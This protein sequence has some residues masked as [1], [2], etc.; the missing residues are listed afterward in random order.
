M[1]DNYEIRIEKFQHPD[2]NNCEV[3]VLFINNS[4]DL[5]SFRFLCNEAVQGGRKGQPAAKTSHKGKAYKIAELYEHL[6]NKGLTWQTAEEEDIREI[7]NSMLHW[8]INN[9][10][11]PKD[12][13]MI[14]EFGKKELA[15]EA[16]KNDSMNQKLSLWLK[17]YKYQIKKQQNLKLIPSTKMIEIAIA[18]AKLQ[19]LHGTKIGHNKILIERW[20]LLAPPSPKSL[21]Y[22][23]I[24]E[25]EYE[26][27]K[28]QL[29]RIDPVYAAIADFAVS[30]GL[31]KSAV[32]N[33]VKPSFF[34]SIFRDM[35]QGGKSFYTSFRPMH[36]KNKGGRI[37][38]V[39]VPITVIQEINTIYLTTL[40]EDRKNRY[41]MKCNDDLDYMWFREDGKKIEAHDLDLAFRK[42]S[43]EMNR[44]M[45]INNIKPHTLRHSFATW[46]VIRGAKQLGINLLTLN[47]GEIPNLI[48]WVQLQLAHVSDTTTNIYIVTAILLLTPKK[49]GPV[50]LSSMINKGKVL[51]DLLETDAKLYFGDNFNTS[52]FDALEWAKFKKYDMESNLI[53]SL[54]KELQ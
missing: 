8:N 45:G 28:T 21:F 36:Y 35:N 30:T 7:R 24:S 48:K 49:S 47:S 41:A 54:Q 27:F 20:E 12:Y 52:K 29:L 32:L 3:S 4:L 46:A 33:D 6:H 9:N 42:A 31:R 17:F 37:E 11:S 53:I 13:M 1:T 38:K 18:D 40:R 50:I 10:Y 14:N 23:V 26:A 19:H 15:Y 34:K 43:I 51:N 39:D 2:L 16:I 44:T 5:P 22:N 25:A